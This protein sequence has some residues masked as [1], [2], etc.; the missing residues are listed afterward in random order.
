MENVN[1][2]VIKTAEELVEN[3]EV[4]E[5]KGG[6][7]GKTFI[8]VCLVGIGVGIVAKVVHKNKDKIGNWLAK[9]LYNAGYKYYGP[10][11]EQAN[12]YPVD[13]TDDWFDSKFDLDDAVVYTDDEETG[14]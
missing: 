5:V 14:E 8:G 4:A 6:S 13:D 7:F 9:K 1:N 11:G 3:Y 10:E 12:K 2:E